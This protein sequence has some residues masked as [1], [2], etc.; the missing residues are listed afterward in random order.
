MKNGRTV[1]RVSGSSVKG[2]KGNARDW[3]HVLLSVPVAGEKY[4]QTLETFGIPE[5][6][7]T[8]GMSVLCY[9]RCYARWSP[10]MR[11]SLSAEP[12]KTVF[13]QRESHRPTFSDGVAN[14]FLSSSKSDP[15]DASNPS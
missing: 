5:L 15:G 13:C 9:A 1:S 12:F 10:I 4:R 7:L 8:G 11:S 6:Q 2:T 14:P 3:S